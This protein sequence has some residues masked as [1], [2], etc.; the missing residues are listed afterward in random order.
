[1]IRSSLQI[2]S[3]VRDGFLVSEGA[4]VIFGKP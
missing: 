1:M 4:T 3:E 2:L